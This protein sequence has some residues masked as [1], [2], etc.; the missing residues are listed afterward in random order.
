MTT[1]STGESTKV[2]II[3]ATGELAAGLGLSHVTTR[4]VAER[5]DENI[6]SIHYHFGGKDGLLEAVV[7]EAISGCAHIDDMAI[8]QELSDDATPEELSVVIR[9][10]VASEITDMFRSDRPAW[11]VPVVYQLLQRD[12]HLYDLFDEQV[13]QKSVAAFTRLYRIIDP[14]MSSD[15]IHLRAVIMKMPVFA[16]ADY[17]K[18]MLKMLGVEQYSEEYLQMMEDLIV[19]QT[20]L[21]LGLPLDRQA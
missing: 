4:M 20:Q 3:S 7:Q 1:Y 17:M 19:K 13:L 6:G 15:E 18:A 14:E 16:H 12:D 10:L 2:K 8:T 11:H 21:L 5:S 9:K